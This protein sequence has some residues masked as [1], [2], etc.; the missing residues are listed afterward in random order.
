MSSS[1]LASYAPSWPVIPVINALFILVVPVSPSR[2]GSPARIVVL[3]FQASI[4]W[5]GV[6]WQ[7]YRRRDAVLR[8]EDAQGPGSVAHRPGRYRPIVR[9]G[10]EYSARDPS[11]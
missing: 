9:S 4:P 1:N 6:A 10:C 8:G 11:R 3:L 7:G 2:T 5:P